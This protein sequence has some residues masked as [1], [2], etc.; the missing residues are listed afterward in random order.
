[1]I[2]YKIREKTKYGYIYVLLMFQIIGYI[3]LV[4]YLLDGFLHFR[5]YRSGGGGNAPPADAETGEIQQKM[6]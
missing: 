6:I 3:M 1:M 4:L 5:V 2:C